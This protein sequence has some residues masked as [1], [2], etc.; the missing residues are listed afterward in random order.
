MQWSADFSGEDCQNF[1]LLLNGAME[2][3][4]LEA[5]DESKVNAD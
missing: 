4:I 2:G 1:G 3:R 5:D